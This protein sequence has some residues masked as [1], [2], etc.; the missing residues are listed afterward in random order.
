MTYFLRRLNA[1]VLVLPALLLGAMPVL[2]K[3]TVTAPAKVAPQTTVGVARAECFPV[4][5]LSPSMR[6]DAEKLLLRVLDSEGL[7]TLVGGIKPMSS[8]WLSLN[9][10]LDKPD[11]LKLDRWRQIVATLRCGDE[12]GAHLTAFATVYE[13]NRPL[14]GSIFNRSALR[15]M[16]EKRA[17]F[18]NG[19]AISPSSEP[20]E[21]LMATEYA[22]KSERFRGY[23]YLFGYPSRAVDFFVTSSEAQEADPAKKIVPRDFFSIPTFERET[24]SFVY[25]VP[26]GSTLDADDSLLRQKCAPILAEYKRRRALYIG[27]GKKGVVALIR[28]WFDNGQGRCSPLFARF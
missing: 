19:F 2:A 1:P 4:E 23:G 28:D 9:T 8:G 22:P 26:K 27:D 3:P 21:V 5:G 25:A 10:K 24:N 11:P 7:Y 13:G 20:L 17:S 12:I 15:T 6:A 14:Q 18:W 16:L